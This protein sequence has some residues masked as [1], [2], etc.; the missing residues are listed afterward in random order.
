MSLLAFP[1]VR[2]H[3]DDAAVAD[4]ATVAFVDHA[5][6]FGAQCREAGDATLPLSEV[7]DGD[8]VHFMTG[9]LARLGKRVRSRRCRA[10]HRSCS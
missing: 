10:A 4:T 7:V 8:A 9:R 5:R 6:K 2:Q 1:M 3:L